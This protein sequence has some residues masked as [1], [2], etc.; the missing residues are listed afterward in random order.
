MQYW[1]GRI[2]KVKNKHGQEVNSFTMEPCNCLDQLLQHVDPSTIQGYKK[3]MQDIIQGICYHNLNFETLNRY[4]LDFNKEA[5]DTFWEKVISYYDLH[6]T[7][8]I[9]S[10]GI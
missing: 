5:F 3:F 10:Y 9:K 8:E 7:K 4:L 1:M 2:H 6:A